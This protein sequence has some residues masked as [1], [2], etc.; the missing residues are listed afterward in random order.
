[1]YSVLQRDKEIISTSCR[2]CCDQCNC[3]SHGS[4]QEEKHDLAW[5]VRAAFLEEVIW[6]FIVISFTDLAL[7]LPSPTDSR[8]H[9]NVDH[10]CL[11]TAVFL[12]PLPHSS[13]TVHRG[14]PGCHHEQHPFE[15]FQN[16][17]ETKG[18]LPDPCEWC[19]R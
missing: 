13:Q 6:G 16:F 11:D 14:M 12:G 1:M 19:Q 3:R 5:A 15:I 17:E 7:L 18:H 10:V 2:K 8:L 9:E 4:L